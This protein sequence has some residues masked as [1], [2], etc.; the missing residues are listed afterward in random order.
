VNSDDDHGRSEPLVPIE[1]VVFDKIQKT[2]GTTISASA[3]ER[4][5]ISVLSESIT[6]ALIVRL[7]QDV[8]AHKEVPRQFAAPIKRVPSSAWQHLKRDV[9]P[10][11]WLA[12]RWPVQEDAWRAEITIE[13][14]ITF[15]EM[16]VPAEFGPQFRMYEQR[17]PVWR[18]PARG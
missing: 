3:I 16:N 18:G 6:D 17:G 11:R 10:F 9:Y 12:K 15:P 14:M 13:P 2:L 5:S 4:T 1:Q 8:W 7:T